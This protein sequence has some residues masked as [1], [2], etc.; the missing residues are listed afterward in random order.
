MSA[1]FWGCYI[2]GLVDY[3][4]EDL[5][6]HFFFAFMFLVDF[7]LETYFARTD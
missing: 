1:S 4:E 7:Y 6:M 2:L 5:H 3:Y